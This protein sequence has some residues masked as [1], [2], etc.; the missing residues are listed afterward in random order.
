MKKLFK[1]ALLLVPIILVAFL[2]ACNPD[3]DGNKKPETDD[4]ARLAFIF[5]MKANN[6]PLALETGIYHTALQD[7]FSVK[8]MKFYISG[9]TVSGDNGSYAIPDSYHLVQVSRSTASDTVWVDIPAGTYN[10]TTFGLGVDSAANASEQNARGDLNPSGDMSWS[11]TKGYKFLSIEGNIINRQQTGQLQGL[12][13]HM[14]ENK[15]YRTYTYEQNFAVSAADTRYITIEVEMTALFDSPRAVSFDNHSTFMFGT[16]A[17]TIYQ[18][19]GEGF[20]NF[21]SID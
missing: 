13:V 6:Q 14:G 3:D 7:T 5:D 4:T 19:A 17:D 16:A 1:N 10:K 18:N 2:S 12:I 9:L 11:W 21:K 15:N 8:K 20:I